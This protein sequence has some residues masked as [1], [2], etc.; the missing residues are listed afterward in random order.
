M[1]VAAFG[2]AFNQYA[3]SQGVA[4]SGSFVVGNSYAYRIYDYDPNWT[5][6]EYFRQKAEQSVKSQTLCQ[7]VVS[8]Y[9]ENKPN[10]ALVN[11]I[12]DA[13]QKDGEKNRADDF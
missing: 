7:E 4:T 9:E 10:V 5:E 11:C 13:Y 3:G 8:C 1:L 12:K 2:T 6:E